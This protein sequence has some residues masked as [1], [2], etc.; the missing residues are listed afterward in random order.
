MLDTIH[1]D[2]DG[3]QGE[4][5]L[6]RPDKPDPLSPQALREIARAARWFDEEHPEGRA[7]AVAYP[8]RVRGGSLA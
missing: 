7:S 1:V 8:Q 6:D 2:A 5:V 4:L 3:P